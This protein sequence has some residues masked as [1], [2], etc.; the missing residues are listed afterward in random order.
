MIKLYTPIVV[1]NIAFIVPTSFDA[2]S[3]L[4]S[5]IFMCIAVRYNILIS[6]LIIN[7]KKIY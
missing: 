1:S 7:L 5:F 4:N 2:V 6:Y 3:K